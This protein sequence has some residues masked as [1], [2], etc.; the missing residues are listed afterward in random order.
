MVVALKDAIAGTTIWQ[1]PY[2]PVQN[3]L[4][5][6]QTGKF[7]SVASFTGAND[8]LNNIQGYNNTKAIEAFNAANSDYAV[9]AVQNAV[10][11]RNAVSAPATSSG[12]Y[13]P[14][15]KEL[16]LLCG[17]EVSDIYQNNS[18]GTGI[19]DFLNGD[20]GPFKNLGSNAAAI[21]FA[22]YWSSTEDSYGSYSA[23]YVGFD[24]GYVNYTNKI[25]SYRVRCVLAF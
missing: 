18:G 7:L 22:R 12:W 13:L 24:D 1:D 10:A 23:F 15:E 17:K 14:S 21:Q 19:R 8:P 2:T 4:N 16:T 9:Q 11:Y 3:W 20:N 25:N 6:N 5:S